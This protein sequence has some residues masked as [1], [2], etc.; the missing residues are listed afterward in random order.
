MLF[1]EPKNRK[2][3]RVEHR[4]V[5]VSSV[6]VL[7]CEPKNR[8]SHSCTPPAARL[9]GFS[10]LLRAEKSEITSSPATHTRTRGFSALL[11]AEKSEIPRLVVLDPGMVSFSALLR[12]EKSEITAARR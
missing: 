11:R 2:S 9:R 7:F 12:A 10:A 3:A 1:C 8:K 5:A 6:S 4:R